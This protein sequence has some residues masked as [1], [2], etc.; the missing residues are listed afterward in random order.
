MRQAYVVLVC[1]TPLG[2]FQIEIKICVVIPPA[3]LTEN[4]TPIWYSVVTAHKS[5]VSSRQ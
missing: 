4:N 5:M 2:R 1:E 3:M